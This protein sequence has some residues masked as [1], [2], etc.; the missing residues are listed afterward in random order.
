MNRVLYDTSV[1]GEILG[2]VDKLEDVCVRRFGKRLASVLLRHRL[3]RAIAV[4]ILAKGYDV[5]AP[6]WYKYG[7]LICLFLALAHKKKIVFIE[8]IDYYLGNKPAL[9]R[10]VY[11]IYRKYVLAPCM[12]RAVLTIHVMTKWERVKVI[13][14]YGLAESAVQWIRWPIGAWGLNVDLPSHYTGGVFSSGRAACDW[15]TLFAAAQMGKWPLT[16]VCSRKDMAHVARLNQSVG[17]QIYSEIP[18]AEHDRLL[19]SASVCVICLK[20]VYKSS[21]QIRLGAC[22]KMG[23]PTVTS[24]VKGMDGY[25]IDGVT[26]CAVPAGDAEAV[27]RAVEKLLADRALRDGL[28]ETSRRYVASYT[29]H[30]YIAELKKILM[31]DVSQGSA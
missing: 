16:V 23:V 30:D 18:L 12:R 15:D 10:F 4:A 14:S 17:A 26:S 29:E 20:E 6:D 25:L 5:V 31:Q 27:C 11:G 9:V 28:V 2:Y 24:A 7:M 8:F 3:L 21:G 22:I 13:Q 1:E 19:A